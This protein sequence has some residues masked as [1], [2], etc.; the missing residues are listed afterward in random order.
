MTFTVTFL[1]TFEKLLTLAIT[2]ALSVRALKFGMGVPYYKTFL[3]EP[4]ILNM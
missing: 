4:Y 3:M 1:S 2:I